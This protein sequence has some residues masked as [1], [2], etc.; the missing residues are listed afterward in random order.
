LAVQATDGTVKPID[1][2]K[3]AWYARQLCAGLHYLHS[4]GVVHRDLKP[5][6]ILLGENDVVYLA[7]FGISSLNDLDTS[8][9]QAS[10]ELLRAS[11][12]DSHSPSAEAKH[13]CARGTAVYLAPELLRF[14]PSGDADP[15]TSPNVSVRERRKSLV[16]DAAVDVWALGLTLYTLLYGHLPW[17]LDN[18]PDFMRAVVD[19][20]IIFPDVTPIS[21]ATL[22]REWFTLLRGML[23]REEKNRMSALDA[24]HAAKA[25]HLRYSPDEASASVLPEL[26]I[27]SAITTCNRRLSTSPNVRRHA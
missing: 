8:S 12:S 19:E 7:D 6:N 11:S 9:P 21:E 5:E 26:D 24:H 2:T 4:H 13:R 27:Q 17:P 23:N 22:P 1:P 16:I 15:L 18:G 20:P 3:L 25:L 10:R 14:E